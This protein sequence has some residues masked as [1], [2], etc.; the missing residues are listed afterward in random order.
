MNQNKKFQIFTL[1]FSVMTLIT[2]LLLL[3]TLLKK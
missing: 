2:Q 3:S 1:I